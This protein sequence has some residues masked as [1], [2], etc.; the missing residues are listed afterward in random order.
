MA[1]TGNANYATRGLTAFRP[2]GWLV[3]NGATVFN[4]SLCSND[5]T[6]GRVKPFD[7]TSADTL[8]GW[9][10]SDAITGTGGT[11]DADR[12]TIYSGGFVLE[13]IAVATLADD[14]TDLGKI[15]YAADD[16]GYTI[17]DPGATGQAIGRV[18]AAGKA[19]G[20]ADVITDNVGGLAG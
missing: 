20:F 11:T 14:D 18:L 8:V 3:L 15:V 12:A 10:F 19:S 13:N 5:S 2:Q 9:H 7:G 1:L 16:A 17:T 4:G 6:S